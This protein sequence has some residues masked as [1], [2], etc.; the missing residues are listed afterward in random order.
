MRELRKQFVAVP[1]AKTAPTLDVD[2]GFERKNH[3]LFDHL[4]RVRRDPRLLGMREPESVPGVVGVVEPRCP[5]DRP[6]GLD[7]NLRRDT[8]SGC[9]DTRLEGVMHN[10]EDLTVTCRRLSDHDPVTGVAPIPTEPGGGVGADQ[11]SLGNHALA[12]L[13]S[14]RR[15]RRRPTRKLNEDGEAM[16]SLP[17]GRGDRLGGDIDLAAPW[18]GGVFDKLLDEDRK[19]TRLNS[20]HVAIS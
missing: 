7:H 18:F 19:S 13:P 14:A 16:P 17:P 5:D 4:R 6:A 10:G 1:V 8:W 3:A 2:A 12:R 15:R 20:S 11:I 9:G